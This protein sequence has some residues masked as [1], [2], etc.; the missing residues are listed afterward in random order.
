MIKFA[1]IQMAVC[2]NK[3]ANL[4]R[5]SYLVEKAVTGGANVVCLPEC[6]NS[7]Y[8]T[9]YFKEYAEIIPGNTTNHLSELAKRYKIHLIGGSIPESRKSELYNTCCVFGPDGG[10]LAKFS[11]VHLFD[12]DIPGK[13]RFQESDV[14]SAGQNIALFDVHGIKFGIGICY[15]IRF[16]ELAHLMRLR[17]VEVLLYPGAFNMVTGPIYW[18]LLTRARAV[19]NQV[20][21]AS[22]APARD[23]NASYVSWGN[24]VIVDPTGKVAAGCDEK[25]DIIYC[26]FDREL[27]RSVRESI[28]TSLQKR[29]DLYEFK[30]KSLHK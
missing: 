8:G 26:D 2:A 19:D 21:V 29:H 6:F 23:E 30:D 4:E 20:Y 10:M 12:I 1:G 17:G 24:S 22:I 27:I 25:E 16:P 11:K 18:E 5:A 15:D 7:P 3:S 28:P 14:L 9:R 13:I